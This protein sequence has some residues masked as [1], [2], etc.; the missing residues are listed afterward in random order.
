MKRANL[1]R[2]HRTVNE[3]ERSGAGCCLAD[4]LDNAL[5]K[6]PPTVT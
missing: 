2:K 5:G 4:F 3:Q 6:S 1:C